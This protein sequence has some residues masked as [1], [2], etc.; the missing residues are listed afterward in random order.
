MSL[1]KEEINKKNWKKI[2]KNI[3]NSFS[4]EIIFYLEQ[5]KTSFVVKFSE[6][7]DMII[8]DETKE[9]LFVVRLIDD[10]YIPSLHILRRFPDL[11]PKLW[12]DTG[13]T[14]FLLN[15]ANLFRPGVTKFEFFTKN[16]L[17]Q[18]LNPQGNVLC[19]GEALYDSKLLPKKGVIMNTLLYL[20]DDFWKVSEKI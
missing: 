18:V 16:S 5:K 3:Q 19:V 7:F 1:R 6:N 8:D 10:V 11:L 4:G 12:T 9:P 2:V 13:A 20:N 15:G 17:V 14:K